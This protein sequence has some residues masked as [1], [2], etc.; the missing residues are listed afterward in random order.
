MKTIYE[1]ESIKVSETGR[2]YDFVAVIEN[3]TDKDII[4]Q[5]DEEIAAE[6]AIEPSFEIKANDYVGLFNFEYAGNTQQALEQGDYKIIIKK[7][8]V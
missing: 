8:G 2:N 3:K 7:E 4:M 1:N 6:N 5:M